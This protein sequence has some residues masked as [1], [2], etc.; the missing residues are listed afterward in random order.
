MA[1]SSVRQR[2]C[3]LLRLRGEM[4][5]QTIAKPLYGLT[6]V[7]GV[8]IPPSPPF[9]LSCR[10][11]ALYSFEKLGFVAAILQIMEAKRTRE[12][13]SLAFTR[14]H[15][16]RFSPQ[17]EG[18]VR[19]RLIIQGERKAIT[20]RYEGESDLTLPVIVAQR[21]SSPVAGSLGLNYKRCATA[22]RCRIAV[23]VSPTCCCSVNI[24]RCIHHY[25]GGRAVAVNIV[26]FPE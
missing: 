17:A 9:S 1:S 18:A 20:N 21:T 19:F 25:P 3:K 15:P 4:L 5:I 22:I 2:D 26:Q 7:S 23:K 11:N 6:P 14:A 10:E 8:R 13:G 24:S 12:T 16:L